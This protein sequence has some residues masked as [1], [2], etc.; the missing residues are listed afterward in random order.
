MG[1]IIQ[2]EKLFASFFFSVVDGRILEI[3]S[4]NFLRPAGHFLPRKR[5]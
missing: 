5:R 1:G 4:R 3:Q 2:P